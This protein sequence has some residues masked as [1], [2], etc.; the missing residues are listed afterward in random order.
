MASQYVS[1]VWEGFLTVPTTDNYTFTVF[2]ND[3]IKV[4]LNQKVIIDSLIVVTNEV[5]GQRI[6][7]N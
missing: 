4:T 6:V 3:G 7:S 2:A 1:I 5:S